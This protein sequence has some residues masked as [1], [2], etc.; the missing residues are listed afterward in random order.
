ML[1]DPELLACIT[2]ICG[3]CVEFCKF[4]QVRNAIVQFYIFIVQSFIQIKFQLVLKCYYNIYT[5]KRSFLEI[6]FTRVKRMSRYF[7]DAELTSMISAC[8]DDVFE[9]EV[10]LHGPVCIK[11]IASQSLITQFQKYQMPAF[12]IKN[13]FIILHIVIFRLTHFRAQYIFELFIVLACS[14]LFKSTYNTIKLLIY[15]VIYFHIIE[16]NFQMFNMVIRSVKEIDYRLND[17]YLFLK[18][19]LKK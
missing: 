17:Q 19:C 7:I 15:R 16:N 9:P 4:M 12:C 2:G 18:I 14:L 11:F 5:K 8:P 1:M 6:K 3:V 10:F 13:F